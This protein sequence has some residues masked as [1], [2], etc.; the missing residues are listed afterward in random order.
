MSNY[1][2]LGLLESYW[3]RKPKTDVRPS[4]LHLSLLRKA[5][6][7]LVLIAS[8]SI[9]SYATHD[10]GGS[11]TWQQAGDLRQSQIYCDFRARQLF[12]QMSALQQLAKIKARIY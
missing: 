6:L 12:T 7:A 9:D 8:F 5:V 4:R 10:R 2:V 1:T 3:I 11:L